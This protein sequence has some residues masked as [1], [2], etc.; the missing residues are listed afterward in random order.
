MGRLQSLKEFVFGKKE[1]RTASIISS[2]GSGGKITPQRGYDQFA[3]ETYLKNVTAF[4]A[5]L[6]IATNTSSVPWQQYRRLS[7]GQ[8]EEVEDDGISQVLRRA[9]PRESFEFVMLSAVAYLAMAGNTFFEKIA[10]DTG[11]NKGQ[12]R[13]LY[14]LRP[15]RFEFKIDPHTGILEKYIYKVQGRQ[16]EWDVDPITERSDILHLKTFHPLDDWW[17]AAPTEPAAR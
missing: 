11:P 14:A 8:R 12:V 13:E 4:A 5:I 15:D 9:N 2:P 16:V 17:G 10:P 6:E 3:K 1:S 7:D